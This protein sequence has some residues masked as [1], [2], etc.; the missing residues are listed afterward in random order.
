[1]VYHG[2]L[3]GYGA[4]DS[5]EVMVRAT[6]V[7]DSGQPTGAVGVDKC[8]LEWDK[9]EGTIKFPEKIEG[10]NYVVAWWGLMNSATLSTF[11]GIWN[12]ITLTKTS[13]I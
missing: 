1:V 13:N 5:F 12:Q 7:N 4:S 6:F 2:P 11:T 10:N 3:N 9:E 8:V